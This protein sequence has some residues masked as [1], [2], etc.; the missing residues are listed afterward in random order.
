MVAL[1]TR[2]TQ[3]GPRSLSFSRFRWFSF[4]FRW[5]SSDYRP[6]S[7]LCSC[8]LFLCTSKILRISGGHS[9]GYRGL[10]RISKRSGW[11]AA[12]LSSA[13]PCPDRQQVQRRVVGCS[14]PLLVFAPH[15]WDFPRTIERFPRACGHG[16]SRRLLVLSGG[17]SDQAPRPLE[18]IFAQHGRGEKHVPAFALVSR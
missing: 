16:V 11:S 8:W 1:V 10:P 15:A 5:F 14:R 6:V 2:C 17:G 4:G 18:A 3:V 7:G 13:L 12:R 9:C